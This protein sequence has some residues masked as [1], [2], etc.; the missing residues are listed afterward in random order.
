MAASDSFAR[1]VILRNNK[2]ERSKPMFLFLNVISVLED[3]IVQWTMN[4]SF[5]L[6]CLTVTHIGLVE[7]F[8]EGR[9]VTVGY[10]CV[11]F[12]LMGY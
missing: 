10:C 8:T 1:P 3:L 5:A 2:I 4:S 9:P 12:S 7:T 11:W 6:Y